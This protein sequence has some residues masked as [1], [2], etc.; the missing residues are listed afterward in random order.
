MKRIIFL[1]LLWFIVSSGYS[2]IFAQ[3]IP[4]YEGVYLVTKSNQLIEVPEVD[5][6]RATASLARSFMYGYNSLSKS[7]GKG[8]KRRDNDWSEYD[9]HIV[10]NLHDFFYTSKNNLKDIPVIDINDIKGFYVNSKYRQYFRFNGM[11][12][13]KDYTAGYG[14]FYKFK[15]GISSNSTEHIAYGNSRFSNDKF[16]AKNISEFVTYYEI[17]KKNDPYKASSAISSERD[18]PCVGFYIE[19]TVDNGW[20]VKSYHYPFYIKKA[21]DNDLTNSNFSTPSQNSSYRV[22][23]KDSFYLAV[24]KMP[25][26]IGGIAAIQ[27]RIVCPEAAKRAGRVY[28]KAFVDENGNVHKVELVKGIGA[29]CDK[30]AIAAVM[31]TKFNPGMQRGKPV[32]V[33][34]LIPLLI[35]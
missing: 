11:S 32:K 8:F 21:N 2:N 12:I 30:E 7:F 14:I 6:I 26:P 19:L 31:K 4:E 35:K 29:S 22:N 13:L 5:G 9:P 18:I 28:V 27:E 33:Q 24:E 1:S 16:R 34:V 15:Y 3:P 20:F 23:T 17:D 25:T 10:K